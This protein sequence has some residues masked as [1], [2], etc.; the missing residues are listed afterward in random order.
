[1]RVLVAEGDRDVRWYLVFLLK[2]MGHSAAGVCTLDSLTRRVARR[3]KGAVLCDAILP[4]G[5]GIEACRHIRLLQP[6]I[7][8]FIMAWDLALVA[9]ARQAALGPVLLKPFSPSELM[10]ALTLGMFS[11]SQAVLSR[12][13]SDLRT[14]NDQVRVLLQ[15]STRRP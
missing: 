8:V 14:Q 7:L 2:A 12:I 9:R 13:V 3:K 4:D 1:M 11:Q 6:D 10:N 15:D 5:D